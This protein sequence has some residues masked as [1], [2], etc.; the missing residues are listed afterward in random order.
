MSPEIP[1]DTRKVRGGTETN[2]EDNEKTKS[3]EVGV[4][5]ETAWSLN[6]K[7]VEKR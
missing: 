6:R 4:T 1:G 2:G 7:E 3:D 5:G